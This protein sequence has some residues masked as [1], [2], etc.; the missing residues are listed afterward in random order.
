MAKKGGKIRKD[1]V[2]VIADGTNKVTLVFPGKA[3]LKGKGSLSAAEVLR[4]L[5][6]CDAREVSGQCGPQCSVICVADNPKC[7]F[8]SM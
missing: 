4:L 3:K 5:K 7:P 8:Y 2:K 6:S 1:V